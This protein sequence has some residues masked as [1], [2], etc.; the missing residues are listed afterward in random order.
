MSKNLRASPAKAMAGAAPVQGAAKDD[1]P[2]QPLLAA[3]EP[4]PGGHLSQASVDPL[5]RQITLGH[6]P[7][8]GGGLGMTARYTHTRPETQRRQI[9]QALRR[10]PLSLSLATAFAEGGLR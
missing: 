8:T 6:K 5:V 1:R 2:E 9:E 4:S 10:W 7:T 3:T